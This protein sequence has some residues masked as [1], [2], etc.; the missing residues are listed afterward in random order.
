MASNQSRSFTFWVSTS[1]LLMSLFFIMLIL[2]F[3]TYLKLQKTVKLERE[4]FEN[5]QNTYSRVKSLSNNQYFEFNAECKRYEMKQD[6]I[7]AGDSSSLSEKYYYDLEQAGKTLEAFIRLQEKE[8]E[9]T[10]FNFIVIIEGRAAKISSNPNINKSISPKANKLSYDRAR[11][12]SDFW[13]SRGL[14]LRS[15]KTDV[16]IAGN[17]HEGLCRYSK[18]KYNE[19]EEGKN[20]R[21][22]IQ[23]IPHLK[24]IYDDKD[25]AIDEIK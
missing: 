23:I 12:I 13:E 21:F 9:K 22:I 17:G 4:K 3:I 14:K 11:V 8:Y 24:Y 20:K 1:D 5:I 19:I 10:E 6:I 18:D 7:F 16:I 15:E 25:S 2:F